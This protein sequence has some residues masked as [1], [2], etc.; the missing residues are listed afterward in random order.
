MHPTVARRFPDVDP[1]DWL[2]LCEELEIVQGADR[3]D[4]AGTLPRS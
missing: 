3:A 4:H 1:E 2:A